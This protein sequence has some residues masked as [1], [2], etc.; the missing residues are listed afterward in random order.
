MV[1][2]VVR[3]GIGQI[4]VE[5]GAIAAN[6]ERATH[7][8]AVLAGKG[9]EVVVL[10]ECLN[11]GW[12]FPGTRDLAVSIPGPHADTLCRAA[13][14]ARVHV[15]AGLAERAGE[16]I[17]NSAVLI[18]PDG[19]ILT[20]HRK[21][22]ELDIAHDLYSVG[23]RLQVIETA[24]GVVGINI[25]A[26]NFPSSLALG[27]SLCRMGCQLLLSPCAWAVDANHDNTKEPY[28]GLWREAYGELARLYGVAVAGVSNVG[29]LIA[30]PWAGRKCIGCSLVI[31]SSG[32]ELLQGPY[33]DDAAALLRVDIPLRPPAGRG[34]DF[35]G[36]LRSKGYTG[37]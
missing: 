4:L 32:E 14:D 1:T 16:R 19:A 34:A 27:H 13:A 6:L 18:S 24:L 2:S 28:G 17:Y 23:D 36:I 21:I 5:Q 3:A 35:I 29:P 25:C 15:V 22:N 7:A 12:T 20:L 26:D 37:P 31:G 10:P 11:C 9:C 30:G 8:V 33:G